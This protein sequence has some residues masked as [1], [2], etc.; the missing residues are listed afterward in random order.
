[1]IR[2]AV[3]NDDRVRIIRCSTDRPRIRASAFGCPRRTENPAASTTIRSPETCV[4]IVPRFV[5]IIAL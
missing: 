1:M 4:S 2:E 5:G 3:R